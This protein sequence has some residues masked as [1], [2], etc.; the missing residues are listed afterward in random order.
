MVTVIS[1]FS[2]KIRPLCVLG[3]S[4]KIKILLFGCAS[5]LLYCTVGC[6]DGIAV[7]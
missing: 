6:A 7:I 3:F 1:G 2:G 4:G 5:A